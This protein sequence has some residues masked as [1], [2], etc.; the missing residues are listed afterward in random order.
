MDEEPECECPGPGWCARYQLEQQEHA[1]SMCRRG[2]FTSNRYRRKWRLKLLEQAGDGPSLARRAAN[3][4][5]AMARASQSGFKKVSLEVLEARQATCDACPGGFN[6][7][8]RGICAH[9]GCGC[10]VRRDLKGRY[11]VPSKL[12]LATEKCPAGYWPAE[13]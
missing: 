10:M 4:A 12:E 9:P 8:E 1:W 5:A 7:R 13:V 2:D 11:G 6:N 3:F